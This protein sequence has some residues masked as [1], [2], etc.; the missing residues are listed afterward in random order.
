MGR[1]SAKVEAAAKQQSNSPN[2]NS[3]DSSKV[4]SLTKS[5]YYLKKMY[6]SQ[7]IL[8]FNKYSLVYYHLSTRYRIWRYIWHL[9]KYNLD[10]KNR[11]K[12][13]AKIMSKG[14]HS[15]SNIQG[16]P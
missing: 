6:P 15:I 16:G 12:Q 4:T 7:I 10:L 3:L 5:K 1:K 14:N 13:L 2:V 9:E 8:L 11:L